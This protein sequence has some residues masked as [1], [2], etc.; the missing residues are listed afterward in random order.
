MLDSISNEVQKSHKVSLIQFTEME[1]EDVIFN[2]DE[3]KGPGSDAPPYL[4]VQ[5]VSIF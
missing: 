4:Y 5:L 2:L 3:Q 1:V